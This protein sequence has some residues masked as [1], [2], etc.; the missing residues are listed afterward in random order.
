MSETEPDDGDD[1]LGENEH[2]RDVL[3]L[4]EGDDVTLVLDDGS[5]VAVTVDHQSTHHN[6]DGPHITQQETVGFTRE[7]DGVGL[8]LSITDGL[9][10]LPDA[11]PFPSFF[12]LFESELTEPG[13]EIPDE[14]V[15]GYVHEVKHDT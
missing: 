3:K 13:R 14:H 10:G 7:S 12:P 15:L 11:D 6:E 5:E 9:S 1:E 2:T 4:D 8:R